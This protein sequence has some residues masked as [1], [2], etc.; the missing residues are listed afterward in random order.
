MFRVLIITVFLFPLL[1]AYSQ[2]S[3]PA[4]LSPTEVSTLSANIDTALNDIYLFPDKSHD[5]ATTFLTESLS[6]RPKTP[7]ELSQYLSRTQSRIVKATQDSGIELQLRSNYC[8]EYSCEPTSTNKL[9][10]NISSELSEHNIGYL[11]ISGDIQLI[12][13]KSLFADTFNALRSAEAIVIDIQLAE[14]TNLDVV[15]ELMGY[16]VASNTKIAKLMYQDHIESIFPTAVD[17]RL[18]VQANTPLFIVTSSFVSRE[19]EFLSYT[20]QQTRNAVV[21]GEATMGVA[22]FHETVQVGSDIELTLPVAQIFESKTAENWQEIGVI[23]DHY[24]SKDK[25]VEVAYNLA[26]ARLQQ[27]R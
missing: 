11:K 8:D 16:F 7:I 21:V 25:A 26:L 14:T 10:G 3:K 27:N 20:L 17:D 24:S 4:T 1:G 12:K 5:I 9:I 6:K 18:V 2:Q 15:Q 22:I 23:P 19:W 13:N